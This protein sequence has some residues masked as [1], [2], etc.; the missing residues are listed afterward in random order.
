MDRRRQLQLGGQGTFDFDGELQ[1][2]GSV[3]PSEAP[4]S[5]T[6]LGREMFLSSAG[7]KVGKG[8]SLLLP[9]EKR[10]A[11]RGGC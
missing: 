5:T 11:L 6:N 10:D 2:L 9:A 3:W 7:G 4:L 1:S 8:E